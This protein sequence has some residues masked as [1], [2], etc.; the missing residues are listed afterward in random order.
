LDIVDATPYGL[1][2]VRWMNDRFILMLARGAP[3]HSGPIESLPQR[4]RS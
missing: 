3:G 2:K 4:R 1:D